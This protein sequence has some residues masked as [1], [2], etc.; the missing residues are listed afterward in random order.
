MSVNALCVMVATDAHSHG[1][2]HMYTFIASHTHT[3]CAQTKYSWKA[4]LKRPA[5]GGGSAGG[6]PK[7]RPAAAEQE[8]ATAAPQEE[9]EDEDLTLRNRVKSVKFHQMFDELPEFVRQEYHRA[10]QII[11][12]TSASVFVLIRPY[13]VITSAL[14]FVL[15]QHHSPRHI[16]QYPDREAQGRDQARQ[17]VRVDQ[18]FLQKAGWQAHQS[19]KL[20]V[21]PGLADSLRREI[22]GQQ[23]GRPSLS[24]VCVCIHRCVHR[25]AWC[26]LRHIMVYPVCS[27]VCPLVCSSYRSWCIQCVHCMFAQACDI[28]SV[29]RGVIREIAEQRVGGEEKLSAAIKRGAVKVSMSENNVEFFHFPSVSHGVKESLRS[30]QEISRSKETTK[31]A[32]TAL[33]S[34]ADTLNWTI[35]VSPDVPQSKTSIRCTSKFLRV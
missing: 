18:P 27:L 26:L 2:N 4:V 25:I 16:L 21:L 12:I 33:S 6:Q 7:K 24:S 8:P 11:A 28:V 15:I 29:C 31:G 32:F 17:T 34:L 1:V 5:N 14:V 10:P 22:H 9:D 3:T 13:V 30:T 35:V 23:R 20:G 19:R